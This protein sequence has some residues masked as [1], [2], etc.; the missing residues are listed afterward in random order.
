M[1]AAQQADIAAIWDP[2]GVA[3]LQVSTTGVVTPR[4][5]LK[6]PRV[7]AQVPAACTSNPATLSLDQTIKVATILWPERWLGYGVG[8]ALSE[9]SKAMSSLSSLS[10]LIPHFDQSTL[11]TAQAQS[12]LSLQ[13]QP[14]PPAQDK[15]LA[16]PELNGTVAQQA[17]SGSP[18]PVGTKQQFDK[19]CTHCG[20]AQ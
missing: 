10:S 6:D 19:A 17:Y 16:A 20:N 14:V 12:S 3:S 7:C 11:A 13:A 5:N 18:A 8:Q 9:A 15:A 1:T 4:A 2:F